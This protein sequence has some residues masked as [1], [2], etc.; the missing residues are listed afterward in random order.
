MSENELPDSRIELYQAPGTRL[1][2]HRISRKRVLSL[3]D[4]SI[5]AKSCLGA[6]VTSEYGM[7][8]LSREFGPTANKAEEHI[9]H[10][11]SS[12][13]PIGEEE[14]HQVAMK[15]LL[16]ISLSTSPVNDRIPVIDHT[17]LEKEVTKQQ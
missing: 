6:H 11:G 13:E 9:E 4:F 8:V 2:A 12:Q 16:F 3:Y 17:G 15:Y 5:E 1:F 10:L 14:M 7:C